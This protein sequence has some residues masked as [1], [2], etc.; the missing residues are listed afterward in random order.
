MTDPDRLIVLDATRGLAVMGI[1]LINIVGFAMPFDG[2][3]N[4]MAWGGSSPADLTVWTVIQL[5]FE[6]RMRG[7][8]ALLFGVSALLVIE[9]GDAAG[10]NGTEIHVRRMAVLALIGLAHAVLVWEG[11]ILLHYALL[12]LLIPFLRSMPPFKL[13]SLA[14]ALLLVTTLLWTVVMGGALYLEHAARAPGA[15]A[16]VIADAKTMLEGFPVPGS[17]SAVAE[18]AQMRGGYGAILADRADRAFIAPIEMVYYLGAETL[19]FML[20]GMALWKTGFFTGGW[21][22]GQIK[23]LMIRCYAASLPVIALFTGWAF[24][25]GFDPVVV[26]GNF[27]GWA[28]PFRVACAVGHLALAV[29]VVRRFAASRAVSRV[30]AV[31]RMAL[32][33]YLATSVVMTTI[34]YGYGFG[35][36]GYVHRAP[37]YGFVLAMWVAMLIWSQPWLDRF[38]YGP[39]EWLWRSLSRGQLEPMRRRATA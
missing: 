31:G 2:Y 6:G 15:S 11:D 25:S 9:R 12:G 27:I 3:I 35:L 18:A 37:L 33:N 13:V 34:F 28:V 7:L 8:F 26:M 32:S 20:I 36:F 39:F 24:V 23:R 4:P 14:I 22:D 16:A 17:A 21:D 1:L 38:A 5:L 10:G 19:A 29:L 30:A